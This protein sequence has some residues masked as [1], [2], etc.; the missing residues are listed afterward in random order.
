MG[1]LVVELWGA[2]DEGL[3]VLQRKSVQVHIAKTIT[4]S[5]PLSQRG[6]D[7]RAQRVGRQRD[8]LVDLVQRMRQLGH[9]E[10]SGCVVAERPGPVLV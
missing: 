10:L 3:L 5:Q 6:D 8:A 2:V 9:T 4:I 1:L 7:H